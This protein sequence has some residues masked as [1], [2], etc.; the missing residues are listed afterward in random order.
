MRLRE[1]GWGRER[2]WEI[3]FYFWKS[4][5][6]IIK[7]LYKNKTIAILVFHIHLVAAVKIQHHTSCMLCLTLHCFGLVFHFQQFDYGGSGGDFFG[8]IPRQC[9][10]IESATWIWW[11]FAVMV[12]IYL[13]ALSFNKPGTGRGSDII[14]SNISSALPFLF[15]GG[16]PGIW[17]LNLL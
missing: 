11:V 10:G 2:S 14:F 13:F 16:T 8:F 15:P 5:W 3:L 12:I 9:F 6:T 4:S 7:C 1:T 17:M